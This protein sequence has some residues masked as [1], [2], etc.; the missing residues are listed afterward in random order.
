[1]GRVDGDAVVHRFYVPQGFDSDLV[2]LTGDEASHMLRVLRLTVGDRVSLFDGC[3]GEAEAEITGTQKRS[4]RLRIRRV[5][6][7]SPTPQPS[8]TLVTA[9]PKADR[10]RWLV[11]KATELGVQRLIPVRTEHSVVHPRD[12][13]IDKM[14]AASIAACKQCGRSDLLSIDELQ[15][16][17]DVLRRLSTW[18]KLIAHPEG[19]SFGDL[20]PQVREE[21][22]LMVAIGPEG[23]FSSDEIQLARAA[24][25]EIV[26]LGTSILRME[27]AA[28]SMVAAIRLSALSESS[29]RVEGARPG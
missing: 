13:K 28:V 21:S 29:G 25:G 3:G 18:P 12:G 6:P 5:F 15:D 7:L 22:K 20:L 8:I 26:G 11:E 23:G 2:E 16:W 4:A 19:T 9:V 24:G 14:R 27:T 1:M 17:T 10:F